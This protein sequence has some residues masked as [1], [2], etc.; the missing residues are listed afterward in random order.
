MTTPKER[1]GHLFVMIGPGGVGKNTLMQHVM[2]HEPDLRQLPTATTRPMRAN[3]AQGRE[4]LFVD[5]AQ[6]QQLIDTDALIEYQEVTPGRFYGVPRATV[7]DSINDG[8]D[9]IADIEVY[10]AMILR[11]EYPESAILVFVA[12]PSLETLEH[13]MR[14]RGTKEHVIHERMERA[15]MEMTYAPLCDFLIIND[16]LEKA[17]ADLHTVVTATRDN[18]PCPELAA[19]R[20][21]IRF[22]VVLHISAGGETLVHE[23]DRHKPSIDLGASQQVQQAALEQIRTLFGVSDAQALSYGDGKDT[24]TLDIAYDAAAGTYALTYHLHY[25]LT[26]RRDPPTGWTWIKDGAQS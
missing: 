13:Q 9:L 4:H 22:T 12:P 15:V 6:F 16:A 20:D 14:E 3:E 23:Q 5:M 18:R 11:R 10:G 24:P 2:Q 26:N 21:G 25:A 19:H 8:C 1:L 17:E 7:D